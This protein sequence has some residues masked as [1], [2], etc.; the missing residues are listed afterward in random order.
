MTCQ[1]VQLAAAGKVP[2]DD[3]GIP[4]SACQAAPV[5]GEG[6]AHDIV[7]VTRQG[8]Q[9][10]AAERVPKG[11]VV[12]IRTGCQAE[13]VGGELHIRNQRTFIQEGQQLQVRGGIKVDSS[14]G[15]HCQRL[16]IQ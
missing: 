1:G 5:R 9:A 12:I 11:D 4:G 15:S 8:L 2:Q 10:R 13:P 16:A 14:G 3:R 7:A 6:N